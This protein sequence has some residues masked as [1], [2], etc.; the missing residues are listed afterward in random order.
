[1]S[2]F[3]CLRPAA[4]VVVGGGCRRQCWSSALR[5]SPEQG[6]RTPQFRAVHHA[7][8]ENLAG[9]TPW[10]DQIGNRSA[11]GRDSEAE[12]QEGRAREREEIAL[13][14][15]LAFSRPS[16]SVRRRRRCQMRHISCP[17]SSLAGDRSPLPIAATIVSFPHRCKGSRIVGESGQL[18]A[19]RKRSPKYLRLS[20]SMD[21]HL[22]QKNDN[23]QHHRQKNERSLRTIRVVARVGGDEGLERRRP[24]AQV[25]SEKGRPVGRGRGRDSGRRAAAAAA[26]KRATSSRRHA[27]HRR[28]DCRRRR[29]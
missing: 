15:R 12:N 7:G 18:G 16:F 6:P 3:R 29:G 17:R 20:F 23:S 24:D 9:F 5:Q 21:L 10:R 19:R 14:A 28:G 13:A 26:A 4:A 2:F 11:A 27:E 22:D 25:G 1:M 8:A